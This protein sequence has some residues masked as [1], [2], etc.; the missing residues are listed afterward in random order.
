[1]PCTACEGPAAE[2]LLNVTPTYG[3]LLQQMLNWIRLFDA[4]MSR[5]FNLRARPDG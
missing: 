4:T 1:M 5:N 2:V 3:K